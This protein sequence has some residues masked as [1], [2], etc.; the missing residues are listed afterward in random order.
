[1]GKGEKEV[2]TGGG[3]VVWEWV[4]DALVHMVR[5]NGPSETWLPCCA[6]ATWY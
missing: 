4:C 3:V 2:R 6:L 1:M 5:L